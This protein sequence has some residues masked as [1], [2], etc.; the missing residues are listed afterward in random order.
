MPRFIP[1]ESIRSGGFGIRAVLLVPL[2]LAFLLVAASQKPA[3]N[4]T[5]IIGLVRSVAEDGNSFSLKANKG[6]YAVTWTAKT[7]WREHQLTTIAE[8][9]LGTVLHVLGNAQPA[10]LSSGGGDFPP[11]LIKIQ[12][13]VAGE[14]FVE[15]PLTEQNRREKVEWITGKL[16]EANGELLLGD[17]VIG[18]G[19]SREVLVEKQLDAKNLGAHAPKSKEQ[20]FVAGQLDDGDRK[21]KKIVATE[22]IRIAPAFKGYDRTHDLKNRKPAPTKKKK[23]DDFGY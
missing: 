21:A 20:F 9:P 23:S 7:A 1:S 6:P 14:A 10:S 19:R 2:A 8:L 15:P 3:S 17:A 13:V 16:R 22:V 12:A 11:Q 18:G 4:P 5:G